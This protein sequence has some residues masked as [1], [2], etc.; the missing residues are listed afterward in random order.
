MLLLINLLREE[1]VNK[2]RTG[3]KETKKKIQIHQEKYKQV[4]LTGTSHTFK[5]NFWIQMKKKKKKI[6]AWSLCLWLDRFARLFSSESKIDTKTHGLGSDTKPFRAEC[7]L[8][9]E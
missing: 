3:N 5:E 6:V 2:Q 1:T 4:W 7:G 9:N 8:K